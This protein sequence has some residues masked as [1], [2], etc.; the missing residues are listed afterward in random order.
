MAR[1]V[2]S[3]K[4]Y[5]WQLTDEASVYAAPVDGDADTLALSPI[6]WAAIAMLVAGKRG[7]DVAQEL[8]VTQETVSRWRA[9]P[10]FVAALHLALRDSYE[11]TIGRVRDARTDALDVLC[12]LLHS[13]DER[14]RLTAALAVLR[15][16]LALDAGVLRLPTTPAAAATAIAHRQL[17]DSM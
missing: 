1:Q 2:K 12:A 13:E 17:F 5:D 8:D 3:K 15:L 6:Q 10:V 9:Q 4:V 14:L 7:C 16:H 11:S